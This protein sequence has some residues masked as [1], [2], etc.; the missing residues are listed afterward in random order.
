MEIRK[1]SLSLKKSRLWSVWCFRSS[2]SVFCSFWLNIDESRTSNNYATCSSIHRF[3]KTVEKK[4]KKKRRVKSR[5]VSGAIR[6]ALNASRQRDFWKD[7]FSGT[8]EFFEAIVISVFLGFFEF[9]CRTRPKMKCLR[10][11]RNHRDKSLENHESIYRKIES[12][13]WLQ[14]EA[15]QVKT[16]IFEIV[17][18]L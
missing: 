16:W 14:V 1:L 9:T 6:R 7:F 12:V 2:V 4:K 8:F 17:L 10:T 13:L 3:A 11:R 15:L 5:I 18:S